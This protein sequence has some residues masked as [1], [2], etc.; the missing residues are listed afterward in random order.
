MAALCRFADGKFVSETTPEGDSLSK[1]I[2]SLKTPKIIC[3]SATKNGLYQL[4][5]QQFVTYTT[6]QGLA[7]NNVI[8]VYEDRDGATWSRNMGRGIASLAQRK[9]QRSYSS[10]KNPAMANDLGNMALA[11]SD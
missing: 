9:K 8:S 4:S 10:V 7:N 3:G 11:G 2:V 5:A 6:R 1:S